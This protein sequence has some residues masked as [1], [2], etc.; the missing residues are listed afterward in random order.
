MNDPQP[1]NCSIRYGCQF[2]KSA[3]L[4]NCLKLSKASQD[5]GICSCSPTNVEVAFAKELMTI[6]KTPISEYTFRRAAIAT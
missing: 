4:F 3:R 5:S 1:V 2:N 6:K